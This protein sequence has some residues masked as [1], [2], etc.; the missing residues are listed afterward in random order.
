MRFKSIGIGG[1]SPNFQDSKRLALLSV[2]AAHRGGVVCSL[3]GAQCQQCCLV[4]HFSSSF[5]FFNEFYIRLYPFHGFSMIFVWFLYV[6]L[7]VAA[8]PARINKVY[9]DVVIGL[10]V[11]AAEDG[12][13]RARNLVADMAVL[14]CRNLGNWKRNEHRECHGNVT[15][16]E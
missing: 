9:V 14:H 7:A 13:C 8:V 11:T 10:A 15:N 16:T 2:V 12:R 4:F 6:V 5:C 3:C 1:C